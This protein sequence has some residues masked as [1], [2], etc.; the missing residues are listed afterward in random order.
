[1]EKRKLIREGDRE[2]GQREWKGKE[3][4]EEKDRLKERV[5]MRE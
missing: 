2:T 5:R 3:R 4:E 1:M